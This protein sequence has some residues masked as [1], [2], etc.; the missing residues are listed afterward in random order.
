MIDLRYLRDFLDIAET[1]RFSTSAQ[2]RSISQP[3][4]TR[5]IQQLEDWVGTR[6]FDRSATPLRLTPAGDLFRPVAAR[7]VNELD[8]FRQHT[9][10]SHKRP[11]RSMSLHSLES[12]FLQSCLDHGAGRGQRIRLP[13]ISFG[14]YVQCFA[15]LREDEIDVA[16]V[17]YS[18]RVREAGF[19]GLCKKH[20]GRETFTPVASADYA[21]GIGPSPEAAAKAPILVELSRD[22][23]L[24]KA[25]APAFDHCKRQLGYIGGPIGMRTDAVRGLIDSGCGIGWLPESM[26]KEQINAGRLHSFAGRIPSVTLDVVLIATSEDRIAMIVEPGEPAP[27]SFTATA[28]RGNTS[29][30]PR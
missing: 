12:A 22:N 3:A 10:D 20:I 15:A 13:A 11:P 2:N 29:T 6:L 4:L 1:R 28:D 16:A 8:A 17:Y 19:K 9:I 7:I 14:T 18:R 27:A 5:R 23:Y 30:H 21:D 26:V 24:G 25:L